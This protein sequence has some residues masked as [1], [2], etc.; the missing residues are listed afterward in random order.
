MDSSQE[1]LKTIQTYRA[2]GCAETLDGW[3]V[4]FEE[5]CPFSIALDIH[6]A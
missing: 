1:M 5:Y 3:L 6:D 2:L 4:M